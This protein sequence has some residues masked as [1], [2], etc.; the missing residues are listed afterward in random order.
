[1]L[2]SS[3][4]SL[5]G[6]SWRIPLFLIVLGATAA[7]AIPAA[8][9]ASLVKTGSWG[10]DLVRHYPMT[11]AIAYDSAGRAFIADA[12]AGRVVRIE[13]DGSI[14]RS[15]DVAA[16]ATD[17]KKPDLLDLTID[18]ADNLF[19]L[20]GKGLKV[21][22]FDGDG[23]Q[24][25][26]WNVQPAGSE[27]AYG[28]AAEAGSIFLINHDQVQR[29]SPEG[30]LL[31]TWGG[32]ET[33]WIAEPQIRSDGEGNLVVTGSVINTQGTSATKSIYRFQP[34]GDLI[35]KWTTPAEIY[36]RN[37]QVDDWDYEVIAGVE[38][39]SAVA[40]LPSGNVW[41]T[42]KDNFITK[43]GSDGPVGEPIGQQGSGQVP[44]ELAISPGGDLLYAWSS[45]FEGPNSARLTRLDQDLAVTGEWAGRDFPK[46]TT[47]T[48][49]G[50]FAR[51]EGLTVRRDGVVGA[52]DS[53]FVRAQL[54]GSQGSFIDR[55][56]T[57]EA[58]ISSSDSSDADIT[59][60]TAV[61]FPESGGIDLI[62]KQSQE[63]F[64]Y[65]A[66]GTL[67]SRVPFNP[68]TWMYDVTAD[69]RGDYL[70]LVGGG[71]GTV[72]RFLNQAGT[73]TGKFSPKR[74]VSG[75][76]HPGTHL[77]TNQSGQVY[78]ADPGY[79]DKYTRSGA[80]VA[81]WTAPVY[82]CH[83]YEINDIAAVGDKAVYALASRG[84]RFSVIK[85]DSNLRLRWEELLP[86]SPEARSTLGFIDV[87]PGGS[88]FLDIGQGIEKFDQSKAGA[89]PVAPTCPFRMNVERVLYAKNRHSA[90]LLVELPSR[91]KFTVSGQK[92]V[93][94]TLKVR[95]AGEVWVPVRLKS[96]Y[97]NRGRESLKST[98]ATLDF[99]GPRSYST[100]DLILR[101][102][103]LD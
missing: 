87:A 94:K 99:R 77:E 96:R 63:L 91:G 86:P 36:W 76:G 44:S 102:Q 68:G 9:L 16:P 35:S 97:I 95:Q 13:T 20:E 6:R 7:L 41:T 73:S 14:H 83:P 52:F 90:K 92:I 51:A 12:G 103:A 70:A 60:L 65:D 30:T 75:N 78:L 98:T 72:V 101:L 24:Q 15:W 39:F 89:R 27:G 46:Y 50:D 84:N 32:F 5:S 62:S 67:T 64:R 93:N 26:V 18:D 28:I 49:D 80:R 1:M 57:P 2:K 88:I 25:H 38:T 45:F 85:F 19:V 42:T 69:S 55:I 81:K 23:A 61:L 71:G 34:D 48:F 17:P 37:V 66:T 29:Y 21:R 54:F 74:E 58:D 31:D 59:G 56:E 100:R 4:V 53:S 82:R 22:S 47:D 79:L 8:S 10:G 43:Y 40:P 33:E 11:R 3:P